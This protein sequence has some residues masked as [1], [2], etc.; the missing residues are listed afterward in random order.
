MKKAKKLTAFLLLAAFVFA[1]IVPVTAMADPAPGSITI[2][3]T[4]EGKSYDLYKIFDL[5]YK[6][7]TTETGDDGKTTV[8]AA[9]TI[10]GDWVDFFTGADAAG[11][12]YIT[13]KN[14]D[15]NLNQ[16][17]VNGQIKYINITNQN[18]ADFAKAAL[19][20]TA[21]KTADKTVTGT[22]DRSV[23]VS[24][25]DLGYYLVYPRGAGDIIEGNSSICSLTSTTPNATVNIKAGYP[26]IEKAVDDNNPEIGQTITYTI[27]GKVPDTTGYTSYTYEVKDTMSNGLT[28]NKDVVVAI[29][30]NEDGKIDTGDNND[31]AI[32]VTVNYDSISNG[33]DVTIPVQE[34]QGYVGKD[35]VITY[36]ATVNENAVVGSAGNANSA[37]LTYSNDPSNSNNKTENPPVV[38]KVYTAKLVIDKVDGSVEDGTVKLAGAKFILTKT[39]EVDEEGVTKYYKYDN[40][41]NVVS[42][43]N[44][45]ADATVVTT[46][47]SGAASFKGLK[48]GDYSLVET[49]AP[50]GYNKLAEA[51]SVTIN[52]AGDATNIGQDIQVENFSGSTLP[53]TGGIGT[54]IFYAVGGVLVV[55][56]GV[57]LITR[58]RMSVEK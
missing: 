9:Y 30:V 22:E 45:Q 19:S 7:V 44:D 51:V 57:L 38:V 21:G 35:I 6:T 54:T 2:S 48:N 1:F 34:Y 55:G 33:F 49:E 29:D 8:Q 37:V 23:T 27:T 31:V 3:N 53:E 28:F 24:G 50:A 16:I 40:V 47:D 20:Y 11:A 42:W 39:V 18:I 5:T 56:A 4:V 26:T 41:N 32:I 10:D 58:K 43:V 17:T 25:L 46:D 52:Y 13:D 15:G 12:G 14:D 36:T